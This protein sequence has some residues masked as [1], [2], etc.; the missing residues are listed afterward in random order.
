MNSVTYIAV[1]RT[2]ITGNT[3]HVTTIHRCVTSPL[4]QKTQPLVLLRVGPCLHSC[5]LATPWSNPL[6][7]Y[8]PIHTLIPTFALQVFRV[9]WC[10][11]YPF[12]PCVLHALSTWIFSS[13]FK[14]KRISLVIHT[15]NFT[16][17]SE[18]PVTAHLTYGTKADAWETRKS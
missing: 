8:R 10:I 15:F 1:E 11:H 5:C 13:L 9:K 6:Q 3:C 14:I 7:Y 18:S 2:C 16:T 17:C 4:T 12:L